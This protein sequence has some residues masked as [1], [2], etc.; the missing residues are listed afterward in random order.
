MI[1]PTKDTLE[2]WVEQSKMFGASLNNKARENINQSPNRTVG[3]TSFMDF[4]GSLNP[5]DAIEVDSRMK[6]MGGAIMNTNR[7]DR[8]DGYGTVPNRINFTSQ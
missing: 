1:I 3:Q 4:G 8:S 7:T 2:A 6:S 5:Y